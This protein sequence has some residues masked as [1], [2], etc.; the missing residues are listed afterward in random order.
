M[1]NVT[2]LIAEVIRLLNEADNSS[3]GEVGDGSGTVTV[4]TTTTITD[5]L[6]EAIKETCRT[7]LYVPAK[8]TVTQTEH[9][10]TLVL[11]VLEVLQMG[12]RA[13]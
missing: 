6:N 3:V 9:I 8:G 10:I 7:C 1:A 5:Y 2:T 4:D 13:S 11:L 12:Y